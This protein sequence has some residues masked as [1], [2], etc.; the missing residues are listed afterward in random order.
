MPAPNYWSQTLRARATRRRVIVTSAA[1]SAAAALLAACGSGKSSSTGSGA[2]GLLTKPV[3]T[4]KQ[5]RPGGTFNFYRAN[6]PGNL[7]P[8][9]EQTSS[10]NVTSRANGKL[11]QVK[12]G[13]LAPSQFE[14]GGALAESWEWA[15]DGLTLTMKLRPDAGYAPLPPVNGRK[16]DVEDVAFAFNRYM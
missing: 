7:D 10:I 6:D 2:S 4:S 9:V 11:F 16:V 13:Y 15:G 12:P 8:A 3:D 5:A 14:I 1:T